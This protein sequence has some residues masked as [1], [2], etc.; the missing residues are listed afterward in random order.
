LIEN[1]VKYRGAKMNI[2]IYCLATGNF[3]F[4]NFS[5]KEIE[6]A[7]DEAIEIFEQVDKTYK[8]S[9]TIK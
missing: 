9:K 4:K 6:K 3:T 2:G 8:R 5:K 1:N 7:I